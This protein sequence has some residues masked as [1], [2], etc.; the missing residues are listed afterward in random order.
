MISPLNANAAVGDTATS[1]LGGLGT[2]AFLKLLVAQLRYQNPMDPSDG[3]AMLQQTAQFTT[4]ETLRS[5]AEAQQQLMGFSQLSLAVGLMGKQVMAVGPDGAPVEGSVDGIG[6]G[7]DGPV[8]TI[9]EVEVP[10]ANVL[11]IKP[12]EVT[13]A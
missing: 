8:L 4:V 2:D 7:S 13:E 3:T 9:R 1:G 5:L 10:L 12:P 6:F 11:E